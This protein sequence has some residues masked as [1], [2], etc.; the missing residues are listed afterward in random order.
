MEFIR[1]T[2]E[3]SGISGVVPAGWVEAEPGVWLRHADET[4]ST[5]LVQQRVDGLSRAEIIDLVM[6]GENL[7]MLPEHAGVVESSNLIWDW[8]RG[9]A[10]IPTLKVVDLAL[11]QHENWICIVLLGT[12]P[13]E[14]DDL[15]DS[16]F[17]PAIKGADPAGARHRVRPPARGA[18]RG[19]QADDPGKQE[20]PEERAM[21][22]FPDAV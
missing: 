4:D 21:A 22:R 1:F 9:K 3:D 2:N 14:V 13:G 11:A 19:V 7:D 12:T 17:V 6:S 8:Y 10:S 20:R 16:V 15:H 5:H 18:R